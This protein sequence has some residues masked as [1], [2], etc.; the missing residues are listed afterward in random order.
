MNVRGIAPVQARFGIMSTLPISADELLRDIEAL[1]YPR[2][3]HLLVTTGRGLAG[4]PELTGVLESLNSRGQ[5]ERFAALSLAEAAGAA[6]FVIGALRDPDPEVSGYAVILADRLGVAD[7]VF[8]ELLEDP[9][10]RSGPPSTGSSG[11]VGGRS[12]P[13]GCSTRYGSDGT[14]ATRP[15]CW[16]PAEPTRSRRGSVSSRTLSRTGGRWPCGTPVSSSI[17]PNATSPSSRGSCVPLGGGGTTKEWRPRPR[18]IRT[19]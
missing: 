15:G 4:R 16:P 5:Y 1:P 8:E 6:A 12:R 7:E 10:S 14:T 19:V 3:C 18:T 13:S 17:T 9:P 11:A 2:R